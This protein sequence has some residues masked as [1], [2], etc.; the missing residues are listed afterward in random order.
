MLAGAAMMNVGVD[1]VGIRTLCGIFKIV[2]IPVC[3]WEILCP[4]TCISHMIHLTATGILK[5][6]LC[7]HQM[8]E[9]NKNLQSIANES[10]KRADVEK[11]G[12]L[13]ETEYDD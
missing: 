8:A 13:D 12:L 4:S 10:E 7:F 6:P 2:Y 5:S 9:E 11:T 3:S 1:K